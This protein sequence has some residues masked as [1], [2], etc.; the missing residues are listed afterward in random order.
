MAGPFDDT[1]AA[2]EV[3]PHRETDNPVRFVAAVP[4]AAAAAAAAA[5]ARMTLRNPHLLETEEEWIGWE[6]FHKDQDLNAV[7]EVLLQHAAVAVAD[8][9]ERPVVVVA[10]VA[11]VAWPAVA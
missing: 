8:A 9:V 1:Q 7:M 2:Q 4:A 3:E 5:V 11:V 6:H 10:T